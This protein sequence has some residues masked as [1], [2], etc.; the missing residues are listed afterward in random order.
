MWMLEAT[1]DL[2]SLPLEIWRTVL[3]LALAVPFAQIPWKI[4]PQEYLDYRI[5]PSDVADTLKFVCRGWNAIIQSIEKE[6]GR[7]SVPRIREF[8]R[9]S[10]SDSD[11]TFHYTRSRKRIPPHFFVQSSGSFSSFLLP[12][13]S[14]I[15]SV[16]FSKATAQAMLNLSKTEPQCGIHQRQLFIQLAGDGAILTQLALPNTNANIS[17]FIY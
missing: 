5:A 4:R 10:Q 3:P 2:R 13:I 7:S 9:V 11:N 1:S 12:K 14:N 15:L 8:L 16:L 6:S 17:T